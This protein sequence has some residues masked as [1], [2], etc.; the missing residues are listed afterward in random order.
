MKIRHEGPHP[1][2]HWQ[3]RAAL[4]LELPDG[5]EISV[6]EWSLAGF[7]WPSDAPAKPETAVLG[8]PFQG[9]DIR[10]PVRLKPVPGTEEVRFDGLSGRQRETLAI[11]YQSIL[12]GKMATSAEVITALDTPV[13]LV[14]MGESEADLA[15]QTAQP[16]PRMLRAALTLTTYVLMAMFVLGVLGSQILTRADRVDILHGRIVTGRL[17]QET[18]RAGYIRKLLVAPGDRV[19]A[20]QRLAE[21]L[22]PE[23]EAAV[24]RARA[25]TQLAELELEDMEAVIAGLIPLQPEFR[26]DHARTLVRQGYARFPEIRGLRAVLQDWDLAD[27]TAPLPYGF[28]PLGEALILLRRAA[29]E[30]R[31]IL[32]GHRQ[33]L[34]QRKNMARSGYISALA[35][36]EVVSVDV[37]EGQYLRA[38]STAVTLRGHAPLR[39]VGWASDRLAET[40]HAGMPA[41]MGLNAGGER[42]RLQG[43]VV[44]VMAGDHPTRPGEFGLMVTVQASAGAEVPETLLHEGLPVNLYGHRQ[45]LSGLMARVGLR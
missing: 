29:E 39:A 30:Q 32:R 31:I 21:L 13:D 23:A 14:P 38:G 8:I 5:T 2:L 16:A 11:F 24:R 15:E 44:E 18:Q 17:V 36:G 37:M 34:T 10:F 42:L 12:S 20:G 33:E 3:V 28:D 9:V 1:D 25:A 4:T 41:T 6:P 19:S 35:D 45:I 40:I 7:S 22:D 27:T 26:R 43:T